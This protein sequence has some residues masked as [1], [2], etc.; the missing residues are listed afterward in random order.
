MIIAHMQFYGFVK[1]AR[2]SICLA[3]TWIYGRA[4]GEN[5]GSKSC[6]VRWK[7][8]ILAIRSIRKNSD[9][10]DEEP[11]FRRFTL[12]QCIRGIDLKRAKRCS[13]SRPARERYF[14]VG[15]HCFFRTRKVTA[16][17]LVCQKSSYMGPRKAVA[18]LMPRTKTAKTGEDG[19]GDSSLLQLSF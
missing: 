9:F 18:F 13:H 10:Y 7:P 15:L 16:D 3:G 6:Y 4:D 12:L 11:K 1:Y 2:F 8:E 14:P 17:M 5:T 19:W